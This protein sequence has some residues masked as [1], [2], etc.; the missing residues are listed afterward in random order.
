MK[1]KKKPKKGA[2]IPRTVPLEWYIPDNIRAG[3]ATNIVV[4]NTEQEFVI[5]FFEAEKPI[6]LGPPEEAEKIMKSLESVKAKCIARVVVAPAR[7]E[8]F[9]SVLQASWTRYKSARVEG[10]SS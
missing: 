8:S 1:G 9:I 10:K 4:Q 3:Y 2:E 6:I 7:L 5:S